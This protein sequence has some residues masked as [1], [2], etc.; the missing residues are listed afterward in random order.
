MPGLPGS[1]TLMPASRKSA[2]IE[3]ISRPKSGKM[4]RR[5]GPLDELAVHVVVVVV[6][7]AED[8][9]LLLVAASS[10]A[11]ATLSKAEK[12]GGKWMCEFT[13][14][15]DRGTVAAFRQCANLGRRAEAAQVHRVR[16]RLAVPIVNPF[17]LH[18]IA[19][20]TRSTL[21]GGKCRP[22]P[23]ASFGRFLDRLR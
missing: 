13:R 19:A 11:C 22:M 9:D 18:A 20:A 4:P 2:C 1:F 23:S 14:G 7:D 5:A 10:T 6:A 21:R 17:L 16:R 8:A 3:M 15:G 12:F